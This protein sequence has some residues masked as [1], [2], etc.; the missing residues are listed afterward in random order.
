M[1]SAAEVAAADGCPECAYEVANGE[2]GPYDFHTCDAD[3]VAATFAPD[4]A[5]EHADDV[6]ARE[7]AAEWDAAG[8]EA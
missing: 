5:D 4:P 2:A 7:A 6:D 8:E 3:A 1:P